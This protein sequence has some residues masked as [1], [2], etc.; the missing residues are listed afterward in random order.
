MKTFSLDQKAMLED[1]QGLMEIRSTN[2]DCGEVSECAPLGRGIYDALA[3]VVALGERY[4][5]RTQMLDGYCCWLE[6]GQGDRMIAALTHVDTVPVEAMGWRAPPFGATLLDGKVYGRGV[7]DDKG[8]TI[9]AIHAMKA[10]LESEE[11]LDKRIRLIVGGD[12]ESGVWA[13]MERYK[14]TEEL[15]FCA[16]SPDG[17]YPATYA[18]KGMLHVAVHRDFSEDCPPIK[19]E[20]GNAYNT[21]PAS[22]RALIDG[23]WYSAEG[24]AAHASTPELGVNAL[25]ELCAFL[26]DEGVEHPFIQMVDNTDRIGLCEAFVDEPSGALTMNPAIVETSG[27]KIVL[28]CDLRI[29]VTYRPED[30]VARMQRDLAPYGFDVD[31]EMFLPPLYVR[32]DSALVTTLQEIYHEYTGRGEAPVSTGGGSYARAFENAV[33]FGPGLPD[34][35]ETAHKTN[36]CWALENMQLTFQI[37]AGAMDR[38]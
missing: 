19:V 23:V 6:I 21:V 22:A 1:L 33:A 29:P 9:L 27:G 5:F 18:E 2:G 28:K 15:P 37:I 31:M 34:E 16:F 38:L 24:K 36:E 10:I 35:E 3:Y 26:D 12:E 8:P 11:P 7:C 32:R 13:C 4:G 20:A 17:L 30:V 14:R 25:Q